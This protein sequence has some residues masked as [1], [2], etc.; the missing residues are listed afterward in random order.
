MLSAGDG[1]R[2]ERAF[3]INHAIVR[4]EPH[5]NG[6]LLALGLSPAASLKWGR[7]RQ[8]TGSL[9]HTNAA[10]VALGARERAAIEQR[11]L[12]ARQPRA[13]GG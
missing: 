10:S 8:L 4:S 5:C 11:A 1:V 3:T 7:A 13:R 9:G 6:L 2:L 12:L